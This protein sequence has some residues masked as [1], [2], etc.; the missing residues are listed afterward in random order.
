MP[1]NAGW[2]GRRGS[3]HRCA[4]SAFIPRRNCWAPYAAQ[5]RDLRTWLAN[6]EI[7][8]DRGLRLHYLA[9][10]A[11]NRGAAPSIYVQIACNEAAFPRDIFT[12]SPTAMEALEKNFKSHGDPTRAF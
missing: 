2:T 1:C 9:G 10:L 4:K 3:P 12:G 8:R 11:L 7:N 5:G 6:A